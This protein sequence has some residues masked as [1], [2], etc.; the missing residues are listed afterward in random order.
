M[1]STSNV[2]NLFVN[3][4]RPVYTYDATT[5]NFTP[6]IELSN[7]DIISGNSIAV[8]SAAIGDSASNMY[9]GSNAGNSYTNIRGCSNTVALG[10]GAGNLI[11]N[12]S[13]SVFLGFNAGT[14]AIGATAN[15]VLGANTNGN[16]SSNIVIG[17]GSGTIGS[18]NI[19]I[20]QA[21]TP[22][23]VS[24]QLRIGIGSTTTIAG[25]LSNQ[26]VGIGGTLAP[27]D[28]LNKLDVSGNAYVF[29]NLGVNIV[30]GFRTMDVNGNF[31]ADDGIGLLDFSNGQVQSSEGF[32]S[33]RGTI[34]SAAIGS[35]TSIAALKKGVITVSAQDTANTTTHYDSVTVYCSD[36]ANGT[37]TFPMTTAIQSGDVSIVF[38]AGGSNVQISN[39]TS[40]RSINW[41]VT[42]APLT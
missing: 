9:V 31:R 30:P 2:Q 15:V 41:S 33:S 14:G 26:W 4:F 6:K 16:G 29:G 11:S 35:L 36:P 38:Q 7:I 37:Y 3:V 32:Y 10:V 24:N 8:F 18:S 25:N 42:Y 23:N 39:A 27:Y 12:V 19:L 28:P 1:S 22:G 20:G 13:N 21:I 5:S 34:T 17:T 40:V